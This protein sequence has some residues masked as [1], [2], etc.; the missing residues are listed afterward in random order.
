MS[1]SRDNLKI[2]LQKFIA[3]CG[4][5]SRRKAETMILEGKVTVNG[6]VARELGTKVDPYYDVVSVEG[7]QLDPDSVNK[8]Y[9]VMNK[10]RG[11]V[12]TV[13][14]PEG[15]PTV[16]DLCK[17]FAE[18]IYPVGRLD[19]LSEG[20]LLLTNDGDF[21]N[22]VMHP[23]FQVTKVYEVK[24]FGAVDQE[25]LRNLRAGA[26]LEGVKLSPK[27]VRIIKQLKAK[28]WLEFRLEEGRNREIRRICEA[29]GLTVDKLKRVAIGGLSIESISTG[30]YR[31][32]GKR[33]LV[34]AIGLD[35]EGKKAKE[36]VSGKKTVNIKA[37]G[38]QQATAADDKSFRKFRR[39]Q[40]FDTMKSIKEFKKKVEES[41]KRKP[42]R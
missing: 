7:Q 31:S 8:I 19:Y 12:T 33:A 14:D 10:P 9:L 32:F 35:G 3:D 25:I 39:E 15:R 38:P 1:K 5:T 36:Y 30:K 6:D 13:S 22:K 21:A 37:K 11:Y 27:S 42:S 40:Y 41:K 4:V 34:E 20:L 28:T 17:E 29:H 16:M 2:R 26:T 24:V 23:S 18:R